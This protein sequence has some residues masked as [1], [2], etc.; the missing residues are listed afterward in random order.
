MRTN[1]FAALAVM[2]LAGASPLPALAA[3][4]GS[5]APAP[6]AAPDSSAVA[7]ASQSGGAAFGANV[8]R[9]A[10]R[11]VARGLKVSPRT[12][13]AGTALPQMRFRIAQRGIEQV[14]ARIVVLRLPRRAPVA[15]KSLGW[16]KT[17]RFVTVRMPEDLVPQAGALPRAPARQGLARAH[18]AP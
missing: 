8:P 1:G 18:A 10:A 15:R 6:L 17:G 7:A 16:V 9:P 12:L 11:P 5:P 2:V 14:Q 13:V 4:G 3:T